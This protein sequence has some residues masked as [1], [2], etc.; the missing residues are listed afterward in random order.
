V[1]GNTVLRRIFEPE[2]DEVTGC[3]RKLH[4]EELHQFIATLNPIFSG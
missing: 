3:E 2:R 4:K 1:S